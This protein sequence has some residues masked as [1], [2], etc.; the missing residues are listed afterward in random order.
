MKIVL[1]GDLS[2]EPALGHRRKWK[3]ES[4]ARCPNNGPTRYNRLKRRWT[5]CPT[6]LL[7][8]ALRELEETAWCSGGEYSGGAGCGWST[9]S[10]ARP[11]PCTP[12]WTGW[13][14]GHGPVIYRAF[15]IGGGRFAYRGLLVLSRSV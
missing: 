7:A 15:K 3:M 5:G 13:G 8:N 2:P 1:H 11:R 10:R 12:S 9:R 4:C 6:R 14:T